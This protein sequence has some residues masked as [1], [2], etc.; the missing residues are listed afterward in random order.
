MAAKRKV[1]VSSTSLGLDL[2]RARVE[3]LLLKRG[4]EPVSQTTWDIDDTMLLE[5]IKAKIK[6]C[7]EVLCLVGR[8]YGTAAPVAGPYPVPPSYTQLEYH[9][10]VQ[11]G[12]PVHLFITTDA[13][14]G[15]ETEP[16]AAPALQ[17][18]FRKS[19]ET[20]GRLRTKFSSIEELLWGV[21]QRGFGTSAAFSAQA[22]DRRADPTGWQPA[23]SVV[24][25]SGHGFREILGTAFCIDGFQYLATTAEVARAVRMFL[26]EGAHVVANFA[27]CGEV[28]RVAEAEP[29]GRSG[30]V[31]LRK[32]QAPCQ[33]V[34][35]SPAGAVTPAQGAVA[36][37]AWSPAPQQAH[38]M[39]ALVELLPMPEAG[40][41]LQSAPEAMALPARPGLQWPGAPIIGPDHSVWG[42]VVSPPRLGSGAT[43]A[44]FPSVAATE[45]LKEFGGSV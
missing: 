7:D 12:K 19:L 28:L 38:V 9:L 24:E 1:F 10:A 14:P 45:L 13:F 8:W 18:E 21:L 17:A 34:L 2:S 40:F 3:N 31:T 22:L 39:A 5:Q 35:G 4:I 23:V 32:S 25:A 6:A 29:R 26:N 44:R 11:F 37:P 30:I 33:L 42:L 41:W 20:T 36:V 27:E 15:P 16:G 43:T